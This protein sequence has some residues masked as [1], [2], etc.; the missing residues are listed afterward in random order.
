ML[1]MLGALGAPIGKLL[2]RLI[3]DRAAREAA[4]ARLAELEQSGEL[5]TLVGQLAINKVEAAHRSLFVAGWRPAVGWICAC[6]MANNFVIVPYVGALWPAIE[7]LDL[8]V[9]MPVLLGML[10]LAGARTFEK[11]RGTARER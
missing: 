1:G 7:P 11:A 10:G 4:A 3:P 8:S 6:A 2:D 9:M 5:R